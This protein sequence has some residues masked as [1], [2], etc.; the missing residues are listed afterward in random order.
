[1][2][3]AKKYNGNWFEFYDGSEIV[4]AE[5]VERNLNYSIYLYIIYAL[6][7]LITH[8]IASTLGENAFRGKSTATLKEGEGGEDTQFKLS[9]IILVISD[10]YGSENATVFP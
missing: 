6:V 8:Y 7:F 1:M 9:W 5:S 4:N 2:F 10:L 3:E